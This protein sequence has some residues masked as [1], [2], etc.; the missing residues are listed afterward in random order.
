[1]DRWTTDPKSKLTYHKTYTTTD[2]DGGPMGVFVK[3]AYAKERN[4]RN[5]STAMTQ[6]KNTSY[7][8]MMRKT[9]VP[10]TEK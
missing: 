2:I 4:L 7:T 5:Q 1:M 8:T 10:T 6:T 9:D 3:P